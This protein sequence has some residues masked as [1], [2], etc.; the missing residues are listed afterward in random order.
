MREPDLNHHLILYY[1]KLMAQGDCFGSWGLKTIMHRTGMET[2]WLVMILNIFTTSA[3]R[4]REIEEE[5]MKH[6]SS[7][8][9]CCCCSWHVCTATAPLIFQKFIVR[10]DSFSVD[11]ILSQNTSDISI[12]LLKNDPMTSSTDPLT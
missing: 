12:C 2:V 6:S 9:I 8:C 7:R 3:N 4:W 5:I 10:I 11:L 1:L